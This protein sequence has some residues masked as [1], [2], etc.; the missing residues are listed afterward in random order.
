MLINMHRAR[1]GLYN[2]NPVVQFTLNCINSSLHR[3]EFR[4]NLSVARGP[5]GFH[6]ILPPPQISHPPG[7]P[8]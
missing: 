1:A 2:R 8:V 3:R 5:R 7:N 4:A 6:G